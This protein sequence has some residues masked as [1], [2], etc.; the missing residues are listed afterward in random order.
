M[1][2]KAIQEMASEKG[3]TPAQLALAWVLVRG[4]DIVPIPGTKR[5]AY[6]EENVGALKV[7]LSEEDLKHL[8]EIAPQG[9][10]AGDRYP[11]A[12]MQLVNV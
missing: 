2:V 10:A 11:E 4:K 1:L 12:G 8:D 3:C 6:L 9:A 7:K 5:T